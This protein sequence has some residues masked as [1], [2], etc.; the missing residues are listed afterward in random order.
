MPEATV[1][2]DA[3]HKVLTPEYVEFD[4]VVA[5]IA[6]RGLAWLIDTLVTT[7]LTAGLFLV[8]GLVAALEGALTKGTGLSAAAGFVLW[9]LVD[10]GY[11]ILLESVWSGQTVGKRALGLRVIQESGVR[12]GVL[13]SVLR[14]LVR[15]VDRLP[16][17]Y[18]VGGLFALFS[19][20]HQRLGDFLAGTV[21]IRE[22]RL[23]IPSSVARPDGDS[24]LLGD[25]EFRARAA[26]LSAPEEQLFLSAALRR[27]ELTI[28][29]RL[30][31]FSSLAAHLHE[32]LGIV[33]PP[34]LSD[35]KLCL[36]VS[37]AVAARSAPAGRGPARGRRRR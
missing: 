5:G 29:A 17:L 19:R 27:E 3:V 11:F 21:V 10:W 33:K 8:V 36:L 7:A 23:K 26:T 30:H 32:D 20:L 1:E 14:N 9:F 13:Q 34:N 15:P 22:R 28:E 2:L 18:V 37:A 25:P 12:V 6:S 16:V 24:S 35:E 4:F 31:L